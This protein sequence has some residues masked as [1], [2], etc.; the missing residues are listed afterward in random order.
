MAGT[1]GTGSSGQLPDEKGVP[2]AAIPRFIPGTTDLTE[3]SRKL[4]LLASM[5]PKEFMPQLAT[6]AALLCEGTAFKKVARLDPTK[7]KSSDEGGVKL[8]VATLGGSWGQTDLERSYD[9]FERA[10]YGTVQKSDETHDSYIARHDV[11]FEEMLSQG[12]TLDQ[13][14][15]YVLLRQSQLSIVIESG[16]KL[17]YSKVGP[18]IRLLGSRFFSD[19]QGQR[20]GHRNKVYDAN[21]LEETIADEPELMTG[22]PPG[23]ALGLAAWEEQEDEIEPAFLAAMA[24]SEDAD[25]LHVQGFEDEFESFMQETPEMY[26]ALISYVEALVCCQKGVPGVSGQWGLEIHKPR[27][28]QLQRVAVSR[29]GKDAA[30][31]AGISCCYAFPDPLVGSVVRK[32]TGKLSARG[33]MLPMLTAVEARPLQR[34][35]LRRPSMLP[36]KSQETPRFSMSRRRGQC[37][38]PRRCLSNICLPHLLSVVG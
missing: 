31:L 22:T 35:F 14:R 18:A 28:P 8:L 26:D 24:A 4:E 15:A 7:L 17:E 32:A 20:T 5:W 19:L 9:Y 12:T 6:R 36:T 10:I 38:L 2:W 1:S 11:H 33:G 27:A 13:I 37:V 3:Y 30:S 16:G 21:V 23:Q 34:P 29:R 25:A